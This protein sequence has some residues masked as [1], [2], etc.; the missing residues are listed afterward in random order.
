MNNYATILWK[1]WVFVTQ[2]KLCQ[3]E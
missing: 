1:Y 3:P 2:I